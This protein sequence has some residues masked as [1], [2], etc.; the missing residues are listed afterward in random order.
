M[1]LGVISKLQSLKTVLD[2]CSR[3]N[4][5]TTCHVLGRHGF[6]R[7]WA[8]NVLF[9]KEFSLVHVPGFGKEFQTVDRR[10]DQLGL[11]PRQLQNDER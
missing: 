10:A 7:F 8:S 1:K 6:S 5:Q 4:L 2:G 9:G 3:S 11:N